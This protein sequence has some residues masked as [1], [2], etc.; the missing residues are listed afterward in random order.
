MS[1][2]EFSGISSKD[3]YEENFLRYIIPSPSV[4]SAYI[5][6]EYLKKL[7]DF[8][9]DVYGGLHPSKLFSADDS[10]KSLWTTLFSDSGWKIQVRFDNSKERKYRI[11]NPNK[12]PVALGSSKEIL[13][14][15]I[16]K[17]IEQSKV[18][19]LRRMGNN[20]IAIVFDGGGAKGAYQIGVWKWLRQQS[21]IDK[22]IMGVSGASV[23]ALNSLLFANGDL[24]LAEKIWSNVQQDD[25]TPIGKVPIRVANF[26]GKV[27]TLGAGGAVA[28]AAINA[29]AMA[30]LPGVSIASLPN[31]LPLINAALVAS[32]VKILNAD[33]LSFFP[34]DRILDII[35]KSGISINKIYRSDIVV[36]NSLSAFHSF[37]PALPA[38]LHNVITQ[39]GFQKGR[40][41]L[42]PEYRCWQAFV[43]SNPCEELIDTVLASAAFPVAYAPKVIN[44]IAYWDGGFLDNS[45]I[46]PLIEAGFKHII[47]IHLDTN[48]DIANIEQ[49]EQF[50]AGIKMSGSEYNNQ[51]R[52]Y[53]IIPS[54]YLGD[55]FDTSKTYERFSLGFY[56]AQNQLSQTLLP[57]IRR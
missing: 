32:G 30:V 29:L 1:Y 33:E 41:L 47:V 43:G 34:Q 40:A 3:C 18:A 39:K 55:T 49:A 8:V 19:R 14:P 5:T 2:Q 45:P 28:S 35:A 4:A 15:I 37:F 6:G 31:A 16:E 10:P 54:C 36:F 9:N 22:S 50:R 13:R 23:G 21:E 56:D 12:H 20:S 24:D 25:L 26:A 51:R 48:P 46:T 57:F 52:I 11:V 44:D 17:H 42:I 7:S 38:H 53:H 27:G